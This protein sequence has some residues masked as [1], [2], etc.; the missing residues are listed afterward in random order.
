[1]IPLIKSSIKVR[2]LMRKW[3]LV[4]SLFTRQIR[5]SVKVLIRVE[6][7]H[8]HK[9]ASYGDGAGHERS[10]SHGSLC[11]SRE[12]KTNI[13]SALM[14]NQRDSYKSIKRHLLFFN[15]PSNWEQTDFVWNKYN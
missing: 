14:W 8:Q 1:M 11:V 10:K 7:N 4:M 6:E 13:S 15:K 3:D 2:A 5:G 12:T 9:S